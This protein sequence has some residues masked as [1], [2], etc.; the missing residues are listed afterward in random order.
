MFVIAVDTAAGLP[1]FEA[2]SALPPGGKGGGACCAGASAPQI[3]RDEG[4]GR[5]NNIPMVRQ[6]TLHRSPAG[7]SHPQDLTRQ[8]YPSLPLINPHPDGA[9]LFD[10][11]ASRSHG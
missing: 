9:D 5:R 8:D 3:S 6:L 11:Q 1:K 10:S 4:G 2:D 7:K